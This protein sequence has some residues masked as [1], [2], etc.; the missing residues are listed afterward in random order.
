MNVNF[1]LVLDGCPEASIYIGIILHKHENEFY[2]DD[3]H[4]NKLNPTTP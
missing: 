1:I 4:N 3:R 2:L